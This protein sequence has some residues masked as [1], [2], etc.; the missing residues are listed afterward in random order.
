MW[1]GVLFIAAASAAGLTA[2]ERD[3]GTNGRAAPDT[4]RSA[5]DNTAK[6]SRDRE[7][8]APT[9]ENQGETEADRT[10]TAEIRK[11]IMAEKGLSVNGQNCKI[12]T[13]NGV[14]TLR[15]PVE[16]QAEKELIESKAR[17]VA[18]TTS[19]VNE[20]EVKTK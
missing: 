5:P 1:Q 16:S 14:V 10:V 3:N 12:I 15:G 6:N 8:S 13:Q 9:P 19:V 11:A 4:T 7:G 17:A 20:L 2:C 18:G